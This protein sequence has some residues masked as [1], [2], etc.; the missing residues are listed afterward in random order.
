MIG[1]PLFYS[2][3]AGLGGLAVGVAGALSSVL[4][5]DLGSAAAMHRRNRIESAR[6]A[7]G[8]FVE[9]RRSC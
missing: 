2:I 7:G 9:R 5:G 6:V 4:M 1:D 3:V 8:V